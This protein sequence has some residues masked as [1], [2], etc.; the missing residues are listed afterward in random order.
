MIASR[1][2]YASHIFQIDE[3]IRAKF[4]IES[5]HSREARLL[6]RLLTGYRS[7]GEIQFSLA[8]GAEAVS[9][10]RAACGLEPEEVESSG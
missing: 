7:N 5:A 2:T 9:A 4:M 8:R 6:L 1:Y 3:R 10:T